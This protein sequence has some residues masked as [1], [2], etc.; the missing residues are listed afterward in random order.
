MLSALCLQCILFIFCISNNRVKLQF[1]A[2]EHTFIKHKSENHIN[3]IKRK[4]FM[5]YCQPK[6]TFLIFHDVLSTR[7]ISPKMHL[8]FL[9]NPK[10]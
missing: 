3:F 2:N 5:L 6:N 9:A 4:Y 1:Q 8:L 7:H 10:L